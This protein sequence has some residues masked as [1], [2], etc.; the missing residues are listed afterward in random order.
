MPPAAVSINT[1]NGIVVAICKQVFVPNCTIR[2]C[3]N[4]T[5]RVCIYKP[6]PHGVIVPTAE[7]VQPRL[8]IVDIPTVA[9][10]VQLAQSVGHGAGGGQRIAPGVVGVRY[11]LRTAAVDQ[12]G[13]VAL[14]VLQIE[15]L[16]AIV[17]DGHG[18][19]L[20]VGEVQ[21]RAAGGRVNVDLRQ[22]VTEV[23]IACP[24][25]L[26][27][28]D[29]LTAGIAGVID[30]AVFADSVPAGVIAEADHFRVAGSI[31]A[32][33][34]LQLASVLPTVAPCA[35]VGQVTDGIG[36]Q[37][38][39]VVAGEQ[40]LPRA[41][42]VTIGDGIQ[43]RTQRAGGVGEIFLCEEAVEKNR[44]PPTVSSLKGKKASLNF[45]CSQNV[46]M[47]RAACYVPASIAVAIPQRQNSSGVLLL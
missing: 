18:A 19:Q 1:S 13:H 44:I 23:G 8:R 43:R 4:Q 24:R 12:P 40:I 3:C 38:L 28:I 15:I 27:R 39:S 5:L 33:H 14:R 45:E 7:V 6:P 47:L 31:G 42:T 17:G 21:G 46:Y 26:A 10:G 9:E 2:G 34:L 16:R 29:D 41:I 35:V 36:G 25:S 22:R 30:A 32:G 11:H 37:C 20:V